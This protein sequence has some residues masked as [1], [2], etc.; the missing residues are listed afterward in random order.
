MDNV[1]SRVTEDEDHVIL[2]DESCFWT[3]ADFKTMKIKF[4]QAIKYCVRTQS[5]ET[6]PPELQESNED[7]VKYTSQEKIES[8][9]QTP[10]TSPMTPK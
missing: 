7:Q 10:L 9:E 2:S 1:D 8:V 3:S 6:E 5:D 4:F